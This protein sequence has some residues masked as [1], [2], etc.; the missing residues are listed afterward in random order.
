MLGRHTAYFS[1]TLLAT[2]TFCVCVGS[3]VARAKNP[4]A[5]PFIVHR[6]MVST[7]IIF[8]T[9]WAT[10]L[11]YAAQTSRL[12]LPESVSVPTVSPAFFGS[13]V[14]LVVFTGSSM[15]NKSE[16]VFASTVFGKIGPQVSFASGINDAEASDEAKVS[17]ENSALFYSAD[18]APNA[19]S[20][21]GVRES[22]GQTRTGR[23]ATGSSAVPSAAG[24]FSVPTQ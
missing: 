12:P 8:D 16:S 24:L 23:T 20:E 11:Y 7:P 10:T 13:A 21:N 4:L 9:H 22:I 5:E 14:S 17:A 3:A 6:A 18:N 19:S 2:L 1:Y 15:F